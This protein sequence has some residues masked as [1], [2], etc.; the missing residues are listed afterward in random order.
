MQN[1]GS[2]ILNFG[3]LR[4]LRVFL[5]VEIK[6]HVHVHVAVI[7]SSLVSIWTVVCLEAGPTLP[8]SM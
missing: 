6:L 2:G 5:D 8:M 7:F 1:C 3:F 4:A